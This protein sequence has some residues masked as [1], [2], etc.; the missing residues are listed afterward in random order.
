[1]PQI[2]IDTL[3]A[4]SHSTVTT[5]VYTSSA[6]RILLGKYPGYDA[7]AIVKFTGLPVTA[8][9]TVTITDARVELRAVYHFGDSLAPLAFTAYQAIAALDTVSYDSLTTQPGSYYSLT[10][11]SVVPPTI[12]DDTST[13]RCPLDTALVH[14]WFTATGSLSNFGVVL[15]ATNVSTVKG[16]GS[17]NNATTQYRPALVVNFLKNGVPGTLTE[18]TGESQFVANISQA[19]LVL[20]PQL[21]YVQNGVAYRGQLDFNLT[22]LPKAAQILKADLELTAN[23]FALKQNSYTADTLDSYYVRPDSTIAT[24]VFESAT[25]STYNQKIYRFA[26]RDYVISWASGAT[27]QTLRF[28]GKGEINSLD[29]FALYG[30]QSTS[31]VKPRLIITYTFTPQ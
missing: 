26:I 5:R 13:I 8:L 23:P 28:G 3:Y 24:N 2:K 31:D 29:E 1:M 20:D 15:K 9:D 11:Y 21:I 4:S 12:V 19:N 27:R 18:N 6:D 14:S 10:S 22:S 25:L 7:M 30:T 17:F 16:F